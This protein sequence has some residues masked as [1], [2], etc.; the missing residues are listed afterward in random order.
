MTND[1]ETTKVLHRMRDSGV[2][3]IPRGLGLA[4]Q[5]PRV[6]GPATLADFR[7]CQADIVD[8][9]GER[10]AIRE[11]EGGMSREDAERAAVDDLMRA[12]GG[13]IASETGG[14]SE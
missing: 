13:W 2:R 10:A 6:L 1:M 14:H 12:R 9:Y 7:R 11:Y 3:I 8:L 5:Y 4:F